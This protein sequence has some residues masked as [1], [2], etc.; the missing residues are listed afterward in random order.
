M[1]AEDRELFLSRP[2]P[3]QELDDKL[4]TKQ[5]KDVAAE[6]GIKVGL[7]LPQTAAE[8]S[9]S[10]VRRYARKAKIA[11]RIKDGRRYRRSLQ[12]MRKSISELPDFDLQGLKEEGSVQIPDRVIQFWDPAPPPDEM[13]PWLKSWETV[14]L[15]HGEHKVADFQQGLDAVQEVA[16]DLGREAFEAATHA[17]V[18]ADLY[19][20]AELHLRGGWYVD[21]EHEAL[22]AVPDAIQWPVEHV[23]AVRQRPGRGVVVNNFI[24]AVPGSDLLKQVL[25]KGCRNVVGG[26]E[27]S[28]MTMT[29]PHMF[30]EAV[31]V[32]R[33]SGQASYV[34]L[35]SNIVFGGVM[36]AVHNQAEYKIHGHWRYKDLSADA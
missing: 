2:V 28:V 1:S 22:L 16:G 18:R 6:L 34:M 30:R 7:K 32:Y 10:D 5:L 15:P 29:G 3:D 31:E 27:R 20:Y 13:L 8:K 9:L 25:L 11:R 17:A 24:G 35:P 4:V 14:G 33:R 21:A 12:E 26:E 19:R 36:Q 23:F